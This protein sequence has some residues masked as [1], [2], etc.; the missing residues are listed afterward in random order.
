MQQHKTVQNH[1]ET[2]SKTPISS[3]YYIS[4][5]MASRFHNW[6]EAEFSPP[7]ILSG[8]ADPRLSILGTK[9]IVVAI[10]FPLKCNKRLTSTATKRL[11]QPAQKTTSK[12]RRLVIARGQD[13]HFPAR[14][15]R[16]LDTGGQ[17]RGNGAFP[18]K[19]PGIL[20]LQPVP[21]RAVSHMERLQRYPSRKL[22]EYGDRTPS[23]AWGC[24]ALAM[25]HF[26]TRMDLRTGVWTCSKG[27][28][29]ELCFHVAR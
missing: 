28:Q 8:S 19:N 3:S 25:T 21:T 18:P 17:I 20:Q 29:I 23:C 16:G 14:S 26:S 6:P 10:L 4:D 15:L 13:Q 9:R 7:H 24:V 1:L 11:K 5:W 12:S 2:F 27:Q 22:R